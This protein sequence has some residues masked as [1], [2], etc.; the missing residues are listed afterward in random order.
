V[1]AQFFEVAIGGYQDG[2]AQHGQGCCDTIDVRD[3]MT[4][5]ELGSFEHLWKVDWDDL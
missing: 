2:L 5:F 4:R 3:L 1:T